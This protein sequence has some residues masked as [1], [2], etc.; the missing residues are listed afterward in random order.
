MD[1][2]QLCSK[3]RQLEG[4]IMDAND[5]IFSATRAVRE[6]QETLTELQQ[7]LGGEEDD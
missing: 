4:E 5:Y 7:L 2:Y 3:V 1:K 6:A